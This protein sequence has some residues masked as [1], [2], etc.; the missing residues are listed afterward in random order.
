MISRNNIFTSGWGFEKSETD[1][2][3]RFQMINIALIISSVSLFFGILSNVYKEEY[4]I[5][6][7]EIFIIF[8]NVI[9]F[10]VLRK[11]KYSFKYISSII[12]AQYAFFFLYLY[13]SY[14]PQSLKFIWFFTYPIILLYFQ[15]KKYAKNW[16]IFVI[17]MIL[18]APLQPFTV[19]YFSLFQAIYFAGVL[20]V[21]TLI[22]MFYQNKMDEAKDTI[23]RQQEMLKVKVDELTQKDKLLTVQSK[24]AVMGEMISMIAHQWRQP[25]S[26]V[27]LS[28]SNLQV[29]KMLGT[30]IEDEFLD[31]KLQ[32]I[33][34]TV[35]YLSE[36]I[37]DF[38]TYFSPNKNVSDVAIGE[39]VSRAINFTKA[40]IDSSKVSLEYKGSSGHVVQTY[41]NE[42]VQVILN[43]LNNAIDELVLNKTPRDAKIIVRLK[44]SGDA[45]FV[46]IED[47][48]RGI[49]SE[50]LESIF[51]PY[52]STKGKNGTGLGLYMSQMIMQKQF[53]SKI[54][55]QSSQNGTCFTIKVP[56]KLA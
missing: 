6:P 11:C 22:I 27:T 4:C 17:G 3:S 50:N 28:I 51:E 20:I 44:E 39:L 2:Q 25:L 13:Y 52:Y 38:Q 12:A 10:V 45:F 31:T 30:K 21:V 48:G 19:V 49:K 56:K 36:T 55:V 23:L 15:E 40:R 47:N 46:S 33:S 26:T 32:E 1:L 42:L 18:V 54:E 53:N 5:I 41:A 37:D 34:D 14:P 24:Q 8:L 9:V 29:K 16:M 35:V 43:I 7:L